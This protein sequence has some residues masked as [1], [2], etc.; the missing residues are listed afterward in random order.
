MKIVIIGAEGDV[1]QAACKELETR[2][3]I[4]K[5]GRSSGDIRVDI[6]D[7]ASIIAMYE[8]LGRVDAV[9]CTA[10]NVHFGALTEFTQEQFM[11]G[12][13]NKVMGQ[14]NLVLAG[15]DY[16]SE[17]GSFTLTS[18]IL[19]QD[20]IRMGAGAATANGALAGFVRGAAIEMPRGLRLNAVSPGLLDVSVPRYGS[21]FPGHAPVPAARVGLAFAKSVEGAATGQII[22][23]H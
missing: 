8:K 2:H 4:I 20:P 21:W 3:D 5:A 22:D 19:D 11:L 23:V 1:G 17:G 14:V 7:R 13:E 9:I 10:G 18:G 16:L 6:G 12:L 15:F